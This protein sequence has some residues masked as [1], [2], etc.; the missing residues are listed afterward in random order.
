LKKLQKD[1]ASPILNN[2][3]LSSC[4]P[5]SNY[6]ME[7][8]INSN[9]FEN[10]FQRVSEENELLKKVFYDN[11]QK[12]SQVFEILKLRIIKDSKKQG[13]IN[14]L[15]KLDNTNILQIDEKFFKISLISKVKELIEIYEENWKRMRTLSKFLL[16]NQEEENNNESGIFSFRE[17]K[18]AL[19]KSIISL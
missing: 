13:N 8:E 9:L 18:E 2:F 11:F 10:N 1:K 19:S 4:L 17:V 14:N 5:P 12:L 16:E 15:R 7:N 6:Q 3:F